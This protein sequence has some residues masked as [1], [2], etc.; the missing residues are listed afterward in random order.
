MQTN[1]QVPILT[2]RS[3]AERQVTVNWK[4]TD[5]TNMFKFYIYRDTTVGATTL[6]DSVSSSSRS[7]V[8][9]NVQTSTKYYYRI[10]LENRQYVLGDFSNEGSASV[11]NNPLLVSPNDTLK[12]V[13]LASTQ[14]WTLQ[15]FA[16]TYRLQISYNDSLRNPW[17]NSTVNGIDS[18]NILMKRY[19]YN[20][21]W[22]VRSEDSIGYS[23][24]SKVY[25]YQTRMATPKIDSSR[26]GNKKIRL[27]WAQSDSQNVKHYHI[28]RNMSNIF[29]TGFSPVGVVN[30]SSSQST[31]SF[32]DS[33]L[34]NFTSY[35]Y[36]INA[37]N[38]QSVKS[39]ASDV[40]SNTTFNMSPFAHVNKDT[41]FENIGR[42]SRFKHYFLQTK[43]YDKDGW[44]DS[45]I[46]Y[47]DDVRVSNDDSLKYKFRQGTTKVTAVVFDND[48]ASDTNTFFVH[49]L[50]YKKSFRAGLINGVTVYDENNIYAS[51]TS[52]NSFN[53]GEI[54][55]LDTN[56]N[57]KINYLV[58]DKIRT[59][60]SMDYRGN[61]YLANGVNLNSF[62]SSGAPLFSEIQLGGLSFVTPTIDSVLD[63][64]YIGVSNKKFFALDLKNKGEVKWDF[65]ADAP[66][67]SPAVVS[68]GRKLIFTDVSGKLYGFDVS[69]TLLPRTGT[70]AKW[71]YQ[72]I[73]DSILVAPSLDTFE[74][75][76]V[77]T[78]GGKVMK[79]ELDSLGIV[80]VNWVVNLNS[81]VTTSAVLDAYGHIYIATQNGKLHCLRSSNGKELWS[82]NTGSTIISTP[83][84]SEKN[85]IYFANIKGDVYSIDTAKNIMWYY[86]GKDK[87]LGHLVHVNGATYIPTETGSLKVI[88]DRGITNDIKSIQ[89][90]I[91]PRG[92]RILNVPK[93][94]WGTFQGN[95]RRT[96]LQDGVFKVVPD[97]VADEKS[98]VLFPN[99][100]FNQFTVESL[101]GVNK[102]EFM[103]LSGKLI[104]QRT[105]PNATRY[106]VKIPDLPAGFYF[107]RIITERGVVMKKMRVNL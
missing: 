25:V 45:A 67:S 79:L 51:D 46:W 80:K 28:Y 56:G 74:K 102:I 49:Q 19:N 57:K 4:M 73:M 20:H 40:D 9:N 61:M 89:S 94:I 60:P 53:L 16:Q 36:W 96:G 107:V 11:L 101:F 88:F 91:T 22:R 75:V 54:V 37:V 6:I 70:G 41:A 82:F 29:P 93:P 63:R 92:K 30:G 62:T 31:Y 3:T 42:F 35:Y 15:R 32:L 59:T 99:P 76:I 83:T 52:L 13:P 1:V 7:Y 106:I 86:Y 2:T 58:S 71:K 85:R 26:A 55:C 23:S 95:V 24:W 77:G 33:G 50:T 97:V 48:K 105:L 103:D 90:Q 18:L 39:E 27:Y 98:V 87:V 47:I 10:R 100:C 14:K 43:A 69:T 65:T 34:T 21:Y 66:I 78:T 5:T 17:F 8:D 68:A 44:I 12:K 64:M 84:I 81:R 72:V 104:D 38:N